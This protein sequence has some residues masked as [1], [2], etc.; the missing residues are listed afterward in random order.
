MNDLHEVKLQ[1]MRI[2]RW[3]FAFATMGVPLTMIDHKVGTHVP[4]LVLTG[5]ILSVFAHDSG[6]GFGESPVGMLSDACTS[7]NLHSIQEGSTLSGMTV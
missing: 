4:S 2:T 3:L 1:H 5:C 6:A 7:S